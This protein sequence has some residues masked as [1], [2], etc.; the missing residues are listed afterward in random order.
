MNQPAIRV[1]IVDD[2]AAIRRALRPPLVELGLLC[3][4][5]MAL[6][7]GLEAT[8]GVVWLSPDWVD[9]WNWVGP[10]SVPPE[11][12]R[13]AR[14]VPSDEAV[15]FTPSLSQATTKSPSLSIA[16]VGWVWK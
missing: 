14:I 2:E 5:K 16:T 4:T 6:P 13:W 7:S 11:L 3:Q 1:L 10:I 12:T 8:S 9:G 15:P